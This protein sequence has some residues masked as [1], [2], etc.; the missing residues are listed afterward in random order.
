MAEITSEEVQKMVQTAVENATEGLVIAI[1]SAVAQSVAAT[2]KCSVDVAIAKAMEDYEHEC[3]LD[4]DVDELKAMRKFADVAT[5]LGEHGNIKDGVEEIR[6]NHAFLKQFR[7][8]IDRVG[9]AMLISI[10]TTLIGLVLLI[11]GIG[12]REYFQNGK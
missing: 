3:V 10:A 4:L 11:L 9:G 2:I 12:I 1:T 6:A 5:S 8:K 7:R